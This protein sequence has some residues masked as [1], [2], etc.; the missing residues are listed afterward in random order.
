MDRKALAVCRTCRV[1]VTAQALAKPCR[2]A[3]TPDAQPPA[4][5]AD[6]PA[7]AAALRVAM[8]PLLPQ[9]SARSWPSAPAGKLLIP[10]MVIQRAG[11]AVTA[12]MMYSQCNHLLQQLLMPGASCPDQSSSCTQHLTLH[13]QNYPNVC[14]QL[15]A[16]QCME[17]NVGHTLQP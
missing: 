13:D 7:A 2:T 10:L 3:T 9:F 11:P 14:N 6:P 4:L 16:R 17:S 1:S 8:L 5:P 15:L 12:H